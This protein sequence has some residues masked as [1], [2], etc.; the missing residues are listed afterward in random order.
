[1]IRMLMTGAVKSCE[2][3]RF[4]SGW[5]PLNPTRKIVGHGLVL[6][7]KNAELLRTVFAFQQEFL[8]VMVCIGNHARSRILYPLGHL[9]E[10]LNFFVCE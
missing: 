1:M 3:Q 6:P 10:L 7:D 4:R 5:L 2:N 9:S 8:L